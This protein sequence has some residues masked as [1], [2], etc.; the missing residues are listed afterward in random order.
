M[1]LLMVGPWRL[2]A[3]RRHIDWAVEAGIAV[4]VADFRP[5]ADAILPPAFRFAPLLP[6][7][8]QAID[9]PARHRKS[10]YAANVAALRLRHVAATFQP[11]LVHSYMLDAHTECCLQAGLQPLAVSVWGYLNGLMAGQPTDKDKRWLRRLKQATLLVE[12]PNLVAALERLAHRPAHT[13][14]FP[15]G[16][17]GRLFHPGYQEKIDA[18]RFV[19]GIPES[20]TVVLS[21]RGWAPVYGQHHIVRAFAETYRHLE[22][23]AILV[24]LGMGRQRNPE[25][26]AQEVLDL[27][28]SLGVSQA[29][30]WVPQVPYRDM[31]GLYALADA[32]VNYPSSDAF[33]STLLEAAACARP[34]VTAN[35]P[36]YRKT[37]VETCFKLVAPDSPV[38]LAEALFDV[39]GPGRV[40]WREQALRTREVVLREYDE[41]VQKERLLS[42]YRRSVIMNSG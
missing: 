27:G 11:D 20:A 26:Y 23:P 5:A 10:G 9:Q 31:P 39:L 36:A 17:D 16:V 7:R 6:W 12:N 32:V 34:V 25:A 1:R 18:W 4:C 30:R 14:C 29:I 38:D 21:P 3:M 37:F 42:L 15:I 33:P 19:L 40:A 41:T 24:F 35:L 2:V 22:T 28:A 8:V 13:E